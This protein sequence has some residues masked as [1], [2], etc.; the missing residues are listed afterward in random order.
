M[1]AIN[2]W[3]E[4]SYCDQVRR[5]HQHATDE[6]ARWNSEVRRIRQSG[7]NFLHAQIEANQWEDTVWRLQDEVFG[8][9]FKRGTR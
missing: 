3:F 7:G 8:R 2:Q 1:E 5:D 4:R 6:L 9:C